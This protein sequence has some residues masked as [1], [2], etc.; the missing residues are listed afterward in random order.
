MFRF[1]RSSIKASVVEATKPLKTYR[2]LTRERPVSDRQKQMIDRLSDVDLSSVTQGTEWELAYLQNADLYGKAIFVT[3][4][5]RL[6]SAMSVMEKFKVPN[7]VLTYDKYG[8]LK[9]PSVFR[10]AF[11][12]IVSEHIAPTLKVVKDIDYA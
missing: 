11:I 5:D 8:D 6:D 9:D 3:R 4:E 7:P 1:S 12:S 10:H 2:F